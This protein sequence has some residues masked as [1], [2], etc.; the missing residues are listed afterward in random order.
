MYFT[1]AG[2]GDL[3]LAVA[4][5]ILRCYGGKVVAAHN[6]GGCNKLDNALEGFSR[7]SAHGMW[8]VFRDLDRHA[9]PVAL[10]N[11]LLPQWT[12][13]PGL[14]LRIV[15]TE[16]EA[17]LLADAQNL[18]AFLGI[19]RV[20][21]P[22][23]PEHIIDAKE[24]VIGLAQR[25]RHRNIREGLVP[26]L[27]SG[28]KVGPEYNAVLQK[29]VWEHWDVTSASQRAPSLARLLNRLDELYGR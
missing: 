22:P 4:E 23:Q 21:M 12:E 5:K 16:I 14:L 9:C 26:R 11:Q 7:A 24:Q 27:G 19:A 10:K 8:L 2:E 28:A 20:L 25:S 3:D 6:K 29:F 1:I 13:C 15:V 17:W 18:A